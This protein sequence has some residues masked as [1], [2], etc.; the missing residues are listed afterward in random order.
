LDDL[1]EILG[2]P[3]GVN[4]GKLTPRALDPAIAEINQLA[5]F[6]Q[7]LS[8][9]HGRVGVSSTWGAEGPCSYYRSYQKS[10]IDQK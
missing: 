8:F 6:M 4:L 2:V 1:R 10:W 5:D 7:D 3:A 9:T